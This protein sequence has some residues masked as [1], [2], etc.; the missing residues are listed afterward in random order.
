MRMDAARV[1]A[2]IRDRMPPGAVPGLPGLRLHRARP[3]TGLSRLAKD[4]GFGTPY[5]AYDW[6]GGLALA[7]YLA[8][9]P[10]VAAGQRVFD[11]GAGSG[12]AGIAA[13]RAGA[14]AVTAADVDPHALV[15]VGMNAALN[16]VTIATQ[17]GDA[18]LGPAPDADLVLVADLFYEAAL[19]RRVTDFLDRCLVAGIAVLVGDPGRDW[20]PRAR[21]RKLAGYP[22][23]DFAGLAGRGGVNMVFAFGPG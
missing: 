23:P 9:R 20:L 12:I 19:A 4:P 18:T 8:D 7:H 13:A 17:A 15:A 1:R 14:A 6:G 10:G 11:L 16:D 21:L 22:G 3:D 2:F 5:W